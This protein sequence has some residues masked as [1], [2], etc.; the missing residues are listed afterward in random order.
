[1]AARGMQWPEE[2]RSP[3]SQRICNLDHSPI[4]QTAAWLNVTDLKRA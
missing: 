1:V 4:R 3:N 2:R